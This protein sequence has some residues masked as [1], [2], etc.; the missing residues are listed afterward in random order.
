MAD[1]N[2]C[3]GQGHVSEN[4]EFIHSFNQSAFAC[5]LHEQ[6]IYQL[7]VDKVVRFLSPGKSTSLTKVKVWV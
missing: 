3:H 7:Q 4:R 1:S 2:R 6:L 5:V